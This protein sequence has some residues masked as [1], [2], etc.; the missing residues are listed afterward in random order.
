[1]PEKLTNQTIRHI[2][3]DIHQEVRELK[4]IAIK[5]NGRIKSLEIWRAR[6]LGGLS[7]ITLILIP[8]VI[9]YLSKITLAFFSK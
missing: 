6:I 9:Q 8:I 7:V 3:K 5:T 2:L 4:E 1:M